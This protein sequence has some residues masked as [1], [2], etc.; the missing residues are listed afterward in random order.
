[1]AF[2]HESQTTSRPGL[3]VGLALIAAVVLTAVQSSCQNRATTEGA[4]TPPPAS[5]PS[6][7]QLKASD[8][9]R[10][11][12][13][14]TADGQI[15]SVSYTNGE[16]DIATDT[17]VGRGW[18][19]SARMP[20]PV[21]QVQLTAVAG[22]GTN[23]LRCAISAGGRVVQESKAVGTPTVVCSASVSASDG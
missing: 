10:V 18:T 6:S 21:T 9:A 19:G 8:G 2:E 23:E 3:L 4:E 14:V 13:S 22:T 5:L 1:M 17:A 11:T 15:A 7:S 16:G 20:N 12:Y